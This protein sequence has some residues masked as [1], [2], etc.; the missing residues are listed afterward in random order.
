MEIEERERRWNLVLHM[1][2]E[3]DQLWRKWSNITLEEGRPYA[4]AMQ[5]LKNAMLEV[6]AELSD[7]RPAHCP[8][9]YI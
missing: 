9:P 7:T 8:S 6:R 4:V 2:A 3:L 1:S 5:A